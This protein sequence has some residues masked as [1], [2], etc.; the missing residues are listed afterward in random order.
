MAFIKLMENHKQTLNSMMIN[1]DPKKFDEF[2]MNIQ[3][4]F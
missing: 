2:K 4:D 1:R 3:N